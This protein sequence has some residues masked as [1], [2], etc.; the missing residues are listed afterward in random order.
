M[1]AFHAV[2]R[3]STGNVFFPTPAAERVR[4]CLRPIKLVFYGPHTLMYSE[5]S[6]I[7][8]G[9][10]IKCGKFC[11]PVLC[12]TPRRE[13][14]R[15]IV[16]LAIRCRGIGEVRRRQPLPLG[17]CRSAG[18]R[19]DGLSR[20]VASDEFRDSRTICNVDVAHAR[21]RCPSFSYAGTTA[22]RVA[23]SLF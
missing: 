22:M 8:R 21:Q 13:T 1:P 9:V 15:T 12:T 3:K 19:E 5:P 23:G 18:S 16:T 7:Y 4:Y 20:R 10:A 2:D 11:L 14:V 17:T 6:I